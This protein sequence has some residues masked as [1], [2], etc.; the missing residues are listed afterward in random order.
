MAL[1]SHNPADQCTSAAAAKALPCSTTSAQ[2]LKKFLPSLISGIFGLRFVLVLTDGTLEKSEDPGRSG[3]ILERG[4]KSKQKNCARAIALGSARRSTT[5]PQYRLRRPLN[6]SAW[7][8]NIHI[9]FCVLPDVRSA[10]DSN[11]I[12]FP[13]FVFD[14]MSAS[15]KCAE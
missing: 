12:N 11:E 8:G 14:C 15:Y 13:D 10:T 7:P 2:T 6:H 3:H 1:A 9:L 4:W 5:D